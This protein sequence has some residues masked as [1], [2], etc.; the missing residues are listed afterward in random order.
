MA[1]SHNI[2]TSLWDDHKAGVHEVNLPTLYYIPK[3]KKNCIIDLFQF[4]S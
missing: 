3:V 4:K 2:F 1:F